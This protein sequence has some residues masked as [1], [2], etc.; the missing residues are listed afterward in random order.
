MPITI[1]DARSD[2]LDD[3]ARVSSAAYEQYMP[4]SDAD[5]TPEYRKAFDAYRGDIADVRSRFGSA[6]TIVA[7][8][9]GVIMGA[10]T[11][12][13]PNARAAYPTEAEHEDWPSD[14]AA[15]RL[16]A[17]DPTS[18][19]KGIGRALTEECLRRARALGAPV[20]GLHTTS[21]MEVARAL[22]QRM[23]WV[24]EPKYDFYPMPDFCVEAYVLEL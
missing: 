20:I 6:D 11:F 9:D 14:W 19:G 10:V 2:D 16:L 21:L 1:R 22:Y 23:G 4:A 8:D 3:I 7:E 5:V 13:P 17:V 18:R 12:Y 24:R 15:F